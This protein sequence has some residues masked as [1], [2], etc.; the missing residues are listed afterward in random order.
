[1]HAYKSHIWLGTSIAIL[2]CVNILKV[3]F[4]ILNPMVFFA[5][6]YDQYRKFVYSLSPIKV[7]SS[8][9]EM[10]GNCS[11]T[12]LNL[13]SKD[14]LQ[15]PLLKCKIPYS[16]TFYK[17]EKIRKKCCGKC[18]IW[19]L[20]IHLL[21]IS[22]KVFNEMSTFFLYHLHLGNYKQNINFLGFLIFSSSGTK[23]F[24]FK[25]IWRNGV[26]SSVCN[27]SNSYYIRLRGSNMKI[28]VA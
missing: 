7:G 2:D 14:W 5:I 19:V 16:P 21:S 27:R 17:F 22:R 6:F 20:K 26:N 11:V 13:F 1:M 18:H 3:A 24:K 28:K 8:V 15:S 12:F 23:Y 25:V 9:L 10:F 4:F